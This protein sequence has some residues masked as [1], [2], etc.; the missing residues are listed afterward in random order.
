MASFPAYAET[1]RALHQPG[2][3]LVLTNIWDVGS[4]KAVAAAGVPALA[5]GSWGVAA[6]Q[7]FSDG[8]ALPL[9]AVLALVRSIT[10]AVPLPLTVDLESGYGKTAGEVHETVAQALAA[11]AIGFNLEDSLPGTA[12]LRDPTEQ[13]ARYAAARRA[14]EEAGVPVFLN[15]RT[16]VFFVTPADLHGP[17]QVAEALARARI[18]ADAGADGIFV[19]GLADAGL[20]E[21][22]TKASPLLV[23]IMATDH[24]PPRAV[25][26]ALGVARISHG[27]NPYRQAMAFLTERAHANQA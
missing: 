18:Y 23:N 8:E 11:G 16:D 20:I 9:D 15:A 14:A 13:A 27:A 7:G 21:A 12:I 24:T 26:A 4:A 2:D 25:L 3:P 5:T 6:A 1:F 19:P 22:F 17:D 10:A